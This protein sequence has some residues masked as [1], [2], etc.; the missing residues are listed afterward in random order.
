LESFNGAPVTKEV[1]DLTKQNALI[2]EALGHNVEQISHPFDPNITRDAHGTLAVSHIGAML[3]AKQ[4]ELGRPLNEA[5][6]ERVSW[7]NFLGSQQLSA[8]A[9]ATAVS[10][11]HRNGQ[12]CAQLFNDFDLLLSPTMACLTPEIGSLDM[13]SEDS[14]Q[15]LALLYQMIGFTALFNDTGNPAVSVPLSMAKNGLPVGCQLVG[16]FGAERLLLSV[17]QQLSS[18]GYFTKNL[19]QSG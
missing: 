17:S 5:D 15:Y 6:V 11:I 18:A 14:E 19:N 12:L 13:M 16:D 1:A 3:N 8:A 2:L 4:R 7:N 10:D 9:Y